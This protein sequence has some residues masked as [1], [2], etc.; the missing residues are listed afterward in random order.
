[1]DIKELIDNIEENLYGMLEIMNDTKYIPMDSEASS[2]LHNAIDKIYAG[3]DGISAYIEK[4][5]KE[6][7]LTENKM[8]EKKL[9]K[10]IRAKVFEFIT[11]Q[12]VLSEIKNEGK[13]KPTS[14]MKKEKIG[15]IHTEKTKSVNPP[16]KKVTDGGPENKTL[17]T[18]EPTEVES[19]NKEKKLPDN[20]EF[21][22]RGKFVKE[23]NGYKTECM[24]IELD[25]KGNSYADINH[26]YLLAQMK[27]A[28]EGRGEFI[29]KVTIE[30]GPKDKIDESIKVKLLRNKIRK[31]VKEELKKKLN[32]TGEMNKYDIQPG[33][34]YYEW[35]KAIE[36]D[37]IQMGKLTKG[38]VKFL[39]MNPFD[40]YQGPYA[41]VMINGKFDSI[42]SVIN[43][44]NKMLLYIERLE[45][46]GTM[47]ELAKAINGDKIAIEIVKQTTESYR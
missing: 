28:L 18:A 12:K 30:M 37:V 6:N 36:D 21:A 14:G 47:E 43:S 4:F 16:T 39:K 46:T 7:N 42:W 32:E 29:K 17:S 1:M 3:A 35:A 45:W 33:G 41:S 15:T 19:E 8:D 13:G 5:K 24:G 27:K 11:K 20:T 31:L 44:G 22:D 40:K 25:V 23:G 38:K 9:R 34:E 2:Y 26:L 10:Y